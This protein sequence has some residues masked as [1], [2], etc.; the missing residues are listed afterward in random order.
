MPGGNRKSGAGGK[1][2]GTTRYPPLSKEGIR[3]IREAI[4]EAQER[5]N[6]YL[7]L[8]GDHL[9]EEALRSD[10]EPV[11]VV[12]SPELWSEPARRTLARLLRHEWD[13]HSVSP[14]EFERLAP[15]RHPGG[16]LAIVNRPPALDTDRWTPR[17]LSL[18]AAG[19]QDPGNL[20]TII[21]AAE[22]F[23]VEALVVTPDTASP[24]NPKVVRASA[25]SILRLPIGLADNVVSLLRR[26]RDRGVTIV[27]AD[28]H[29]GLPLRGTKLPRPALLV[30]GAEAAGVPPSLDPL[31]DLRLRIPLAEPVESLNVA[32]SAAVILYEASQ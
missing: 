21:R 10:A 24:A 13:I 25:G 30:L 27:A 2:E 23:G 17:G 9:L 32:M 3:R 22:G 26:F 8:E 28:A 14:E 11:I 12:V 6:P 31:I 5:E 16:V 1:P 20:G 19:I 18:L 15:S 4:R 7:V 29:R